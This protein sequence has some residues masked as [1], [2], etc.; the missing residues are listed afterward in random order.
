MVTYGKDRGLAITHRE[1]AAF[2]VQLIPG[3][4]A[5]DVDKTL[6][7]LTFGKLKVSDIPIT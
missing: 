6:S 7:E 3:I 1:G 2:E 4:V 5:D